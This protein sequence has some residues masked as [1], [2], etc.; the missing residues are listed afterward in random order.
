MP[1]LEVEIVLRPNEFLL[2]DLAPRLAEAAARVF[3]SPKGSV[4][5]KLRALQLTEYAENGGTSGDMHPVFVSVL[6]SSLPGRAEL[7]EEIARLTQAIAQTCERPA[8]NVHIIYEP[9]GAQR[10]AFGGKLVK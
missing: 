3:D 7:E 2:S 10:V 6:K 8:E 5:V 9:P 4:W 1:I